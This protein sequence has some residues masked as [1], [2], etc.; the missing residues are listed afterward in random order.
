MPQT[1]YWT[2]AHSWALFFI[3]VGAILVGLLLTKVALVWAWVI[4]LVLFFLF[5]IV[6]GHGI[7]GLW[8]G[9]FIDDRNKISLSRFQMI[10]WTVVVL[11]AYLTAALYNIRWDPTG[12]PLGI[13]I[14]YELWILM[15][16]STTSLIGSPLIKT[17][18]KQRPAADDERQETLNLLKKEGVPENQVRTTG[19]LVLNAELQ[20]ARWSDMFKGEETGNAAHLDLAK[21]QMFYFTIVLVITYAALIGAGFSVETGQVTALP[22]LDPSILALLGISHAGYLTHKAIPLS[23]SA[24]PSG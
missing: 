17:T 12:N 14:P 23:G 2:R 9:L 7:T 19:Q 1:S 24:K 6:A 15:G 11:S 8:R 21:I 3:V 18:K 20:F 5:T 22:S 4:I 10:L 16:I 13:A